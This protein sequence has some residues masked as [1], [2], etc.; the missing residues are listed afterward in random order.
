MITDD[1]R[2]ME[3][4]TRILNAAHGSGESV[5]FARERQC[6]YVL[7][8]YDEEIYAEFEATALRKV[9]QMREPRKLLPCHA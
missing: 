9:Y 1:L 4:Q 2:A 5:S 7:R 3:V 8:N 6:G